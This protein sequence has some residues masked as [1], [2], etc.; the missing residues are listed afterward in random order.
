MA[1]LECPNAR[2]KAVLSGDCLIIQGLWPNHTGI[3]PEKAITL[4]S[5]RAPKLA[6][7]NQTT[8]EP[9]AWDSREFLRKLCL[10]KDVVYCTDG[11]VFLNN[12]NVAA[13]V[14]Q[15]GWAS[16]TSP[17]KT[18]YYAELLFH[19][20]QAFNKGLGR[21][22]KT[23]GAAEASIRTLPPHLNP[24]TI[25][26]LV[27]ANKGK[28][29]E[30]I[31]EQVRD[32]ST[33]LAYL[34][35]EFQFVEVIVAGTQ[36]PNNAYPFAL[37]AKFFTECR[38]LNKDVRIVLEG[39]DKLSRLIGS[40]FYPDRD[41]EKDLGLELVE[42]GYARYAPWSAKVMEEDAKR[43]LNNAELEAKKTKRRIWKH[44]VIPITNSKP[45]HDDDFV[46][47]VVE[48]VNGECII[49]ANDSGE[50]RVNL[51]NI[52]CPKLGNPRRGDEPAA[53]A[54]E[55]KEFLR[56]LLIGRDVN[57]QMEYTRNVRK[58]DA[59]SSRVTDFGSVFVKAEGQEQNV[60][61]LLVEC[62]FGM[63][64]KH[65]DFEERS[66]HY[67]ALLAAEARAM[68]EKKG[69]H[70]SK[71]AP[72]V[73]LT[74]LTMATAEKARE[75]LPSLQQTRR[76]SAVVE[77]VLS[78]HRFKLYLPKETCSISFSFSGVR[79]PGRDEPYSDE[80][81]AV[82]RKRLM[83]RD[84][85]IE[86]ETVDRN[87]T[88]LGRLWESGTNVSIALVEAGLA[89]Y[90]P[91]G[92][93]DKIQDGHLLERAMK[94][95]KTKKL[96]IWE[97]FEGKS[98]KQKELKVVVTKVLGSGKFYVQTVG[99]QK[100]ASIQQQLASLD[101][102]EAPSVNDA[103]DPRNGDIVLAQFSTD[104][105]WNRARIVNKR[106]D[107]FEVFYIDYGIQELVP[108]SRLQPLNSSA[109]T[110]PGLAQL[111]SLAH[112]IVPSLKE[113]FGEEAEKYLCECI[114]GK[115]FTAVI[116][117]RNISGG[118]FAFHQGTGPALMVTLVA[119]G[120]VDSINA[121]MLQNGLASLDNQKRSWQSRNLRKF[122]Q[123]AQT[124]RRGM[125]HDYYQSE[126]Y[127]YRAP[128]APARKVVGKR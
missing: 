66:T 25:E 67:D 48:V 88:F 80:A 59:E 19:M 61:E 128:P 68:A 100:S 44:F 1:F 95:A 84:V 102:D 114:L 126:H 105:T 62:G 43:L 108:Y 85:Q 64:I 81:I 63:V 123:E 50:R 29:I 39:V 104:N 106:K 109:A 97:N 21:W 13:L 72:V 8:D 35:P 52:R 73:R 110:A 115:E 103:F 37:Q 22:N 79:C 119:A 120:D 28:S 127:V 53:Y 76:V 57:V 10:G 116:E 87:G 65:L 74:D 33:F 60:A 49:V 42:E 122:E 7:I 41:S 69:V 90:I 101:L 82:M 77:Y 70:S 6:S 75:V 71:E 11:S 15:N 20:D 54:R 14:V 92:G 23:P 3:P 125:W 111:C 17:S 36:S 58:A 40:V 121:A 89:K 16:V 51:S 45:I 83:Q 27:A 56:T 32:G 86:V 93:S 98:N 34:L 9:F 26:T 112:V 31:V 18:P 113:E 12:M 38:V 118:K 96:K 55:A 78:G 4:L 47:T 94:D 91:F 117:G 24:E 124:F 99:D 5:I 107:R 30:A 2:V 46:G